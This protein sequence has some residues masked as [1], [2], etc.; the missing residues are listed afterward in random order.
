MI[1]IYRKSQLK[2]LALALG[3]R[4]D[5]HEPD[6]QDLTVEVRGSHFDN[7][8]FWPDP[9]GATMEMHVVIKQYDKPVAA[10]NL[11]TLIAWAAG[12]ED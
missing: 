10:I 11:A 3:T 2:G 1:R 5:W 9:T 12:L 7:A 8:G 6:E 4:A